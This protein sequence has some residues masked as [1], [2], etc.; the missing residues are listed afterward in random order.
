MKQITNIQ[1]KV[2][3]KQKNRSSQMGVTN[4]QQYQMGTVQHN[5]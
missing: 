4:H 5:L 3:R 1:Q 2:M